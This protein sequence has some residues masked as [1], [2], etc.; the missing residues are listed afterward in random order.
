MAELGVCA[1]VLALSHIV[2]VVDGGDGGLKAVF[3][4]LKKAGSTG[5]GG[6]S[7]T[8]ESVSTASA[9][10]PVST[11]GMVQE[12]NI[13]IPSPIIVKDKGKGK[14]E[15]F[16][17]NKQEHN[18]DKQEQD[19]LGHEA[20][21]RLQE[22]LDEEERQRMARVHEEAQ[23]FTKE[24]WENI[25]KS[26]NDEELLETTSRGK[27][28]KAEAKRNKPMTQDQLRNYMINYIKHMGSHTLQQLKRYSFDKL[29]ELFETTMKNF[30]TFVPMETE[31]RER[32]SELAAGSSQ[33]TIIDFAEEVYT[34][35]S[36]KYWKIVRVGNHTEAYQFFEDMLKIFDMDDLVMLCNL[37]KERFSSTEPT[38]DKERALWVELKRLFEPNNDD[39]LWKLQR[40]MH[41]PLK[42]R[43]YDTRR[44]HY[45][46]TERGI[47]IFML[48]EKEYPCQKS[49]DV[50]VVNRL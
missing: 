11:A 40:Y 14:M 5:S 12:V 26:L 42:W 35:E 27:E 43:L 39:T 23:S 41:D 20:A 50:D 21:V 3:D 1:T 18:N 8:E 24:E 13:N 15:E 2:V 19:R 34:K 22:E 48:V 25:N 7:T 6:I 16:E 29:K 4:S 45:V 49:F 30:N 28:Q 9:S 31:D 46:S 38:D 36:R 10:M 17:M 32:A 33:A 44:V 37:V 47:D